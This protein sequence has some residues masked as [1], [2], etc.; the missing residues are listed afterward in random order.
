MDNV[1]GSVAWG[2]SSRGF[3][4]VWMRDWKLCVMFLMSGRFMRVAISLMRL[5][6][7]RLMSWVV[8]IVTG[9]QIGRAHV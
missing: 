2:S 7:L 6:A 9:K 5:S 3:G 8:N 4:R 1:F